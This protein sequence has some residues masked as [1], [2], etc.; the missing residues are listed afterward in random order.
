[1]KL[2]PKTANSLR[3]SFRLCLSQNSADLREPFEDA[4]ADITILNFDKDGELAGQL[5]VVGPEITDT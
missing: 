3:F 4:M 1:M 5:P 2:A